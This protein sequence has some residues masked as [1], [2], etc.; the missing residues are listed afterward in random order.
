ME[1][2]GAQS[3]KGAAEGVV[4]HRVGVIGPDPLGQQ[5]IVETE[6]LAPLRLQHHDGLERPVGE[7]RE[8]LQELAVGVDP[9]AEFALLAPRL[10]MS[11]RGRR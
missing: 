10:T 9:D 7:Q 11:A 8:H 5:H 6:L 1:M 4:G 3:H 2:L